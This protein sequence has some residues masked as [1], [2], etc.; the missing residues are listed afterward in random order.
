MK[1][2]LPVPVVQK[3]EEKYILDYNYPESIGKVKSFYGNFGVFLKA[4]AYI[5]TMGAEGLKR[6]SQIAVLNANY[7]KEQLKETYILPI[8]TICKHE[9]VLGGLGQN[10]AGITTLDIIKRMI[11]Y[12][13]HPPTVYFP[14]IISEAMMIEPTETESLETLDEFIS[15]LKTIAQ[16]AKTTPELLKTAPHDSVVRRLDEVLAARKPRVLW[17][18][19]S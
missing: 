15:V 1:K 10:E 4:Y 9:F 14:L 7:L 16:E 6:A 3:K 18:K 13:Y 11:D 8:D 5:L 19:Q 17:K 12:G 2:F